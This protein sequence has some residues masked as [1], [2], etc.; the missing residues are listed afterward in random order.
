[1]LKPKI[2]LEFLFSTSRMRYQY[3][4]ALVWRRLNSSSSEARPQKVVVPLQGSSVTAEATK[5]TSSLHHKNLPTFFP[6][7]KDKPSHE[8]T[9][10][11][12]VK[13]IAMKVD[14]Y[15]RLMRLDKPIGKHTSQQ[16]KYYIQFP[17]L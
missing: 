7:R 4:G 17:V 9:I 8:N 2:A 5:Y 10:T 14:P 1:M 6:V 12:K 16:S 13:M 11:A 15:A 3:G